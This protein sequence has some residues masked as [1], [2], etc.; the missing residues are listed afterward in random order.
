MLNG[1]LHNLMEREFFFLKN[2]SKK[3]FFL[4]DLFSYTIDAADHFCFF[5]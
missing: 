5:V 1:V 4:T 3:V 2:L